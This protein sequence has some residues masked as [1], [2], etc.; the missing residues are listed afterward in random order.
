VGVG[1][2]IERGRGGEDIAVPEPRKEETEN[3]T[4]D[5]ELLYFVDD[6]FSF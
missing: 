1:F 3:F 4:N 5:L 2:S 6:S